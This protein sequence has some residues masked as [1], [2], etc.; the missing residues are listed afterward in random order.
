MFRTSNTLL[1]DSQGGAMDKY[2]KGK[3]LGKGSFGVCSI[4]SR[5]SDGK[6]FVVKEI[7]ISRMPKAERET[8]ELEAK[9]S[10]GPSFL[11]RGLTIQSFRISCTSCFEI[12]CTEGW[13]SHSLF[14]LP[15]CTPILATLCPPHVT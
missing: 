10:Q 15:A 12:W 8:A 4:V 1:P 11:I 2:V 7:D 3:I 14:P 9:V 5:K 6:Q 13:P